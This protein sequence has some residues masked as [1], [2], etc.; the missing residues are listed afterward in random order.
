MVLE[1]DANNTETQATKQHEIQTQICEVER[2]IEPQNGGP[3]REDE[4]S[5]ADEEVLDEMKKKK[6]NENDEES[7]SDEDSPKELKS[8][9]GILSL[10]EPTSQYMVKP[11]AHSNMVF[12]T[13]SGGAGQRRGSIK[14]T[15]HAVTTNT[16]KLERLSKLLTPP[17]SPRQ[18][19]IGSPRKQPQQEL[20]PSIDE[21]MEKELE[22]SNVMFAENV[23]YDYEHLKKLAGAFG[24]EKITDEAIEVTTKLHKAIQLRKKYLEIN[25]YYYPWETPDIQIGHPSIK[26]SYDPFDIDKYRNAEATNEY[27]MMKDGVM[28]VFANEEEA[29]KPDAKPLFSV[30]SFAEHYQDFKKMDQII[31]DG[32]TKSFCYRRLKLL[33]LKFQ[34][35]TVMNEA[36][37]LASQ[38]EVPHRDFYNVR[39][40]DTHLHLAS[41]MNQKHLLRFIKKKL[42]TAANEVVI[43]RDGKHLT[44][45]QVFESLNLTS[46]DLSVDTLDVHADSNTFHRFDKFNLKYNPC[47]QSRLREI[48]LKTE[49]YI[50]G[51][52]FAE[53]C[54]ELFSDFEESKYQMAEPRVSIYGRSRDEWDHLAKWSLDYK[55]YSDNIRFLIQIPRLYSVHHDTKAVKSFEEMLKSMSFFRRF[56]LLFSKADSYSTTCNAHRHFRA[57]VRGHTRSKD[58]PR[59]GMLPQPGGWLRLCGRREQSRA[60]LP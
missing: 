51:R 19:L 2:S 13:S 44:L 43:F 28:Q 33:E 56:F 54:K 46:Y 52:Y 47:G 3:L 35:H 41:A 9:P 11:V 34:L 25:P 24:E 6:K 58:T 55:M 49:N 7:N 27:Y 18:G 17:G 10:G 21:E 38:K 48:F 50:N 12:Q 36:E 53:L 40:V 30:I 15:H 39:K 23:D 45:K 16:E 31:Y 57:L 4:D 22:E 26:P 8:S 60:P 29:K 20:F 32:P 37:E 14:T 5:D 59:A 42:R 1:Q